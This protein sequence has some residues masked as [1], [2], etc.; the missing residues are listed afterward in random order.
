MIVRTV[1]ISGHTGNLAHVL[2]EAADELEEHG[3]SNVPIEANSRNDPYLVLAFSGDSELDSDDDE[4]KPL[5]E[6]WSEVEQ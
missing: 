1:H 6:A 3:E 2:R 4:G 5:V